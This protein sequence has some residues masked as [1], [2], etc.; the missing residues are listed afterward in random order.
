MS[1]APSIRTENEIAGDTILAFA[2]G[3]GSRTQNS[4]TITSDNTFDVLADFHNG[5]REFV[6][7]NDWWIV[8]KFIV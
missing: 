7:Q 8:S 2:A 4:A 6:T 3:H 5:T 1:H